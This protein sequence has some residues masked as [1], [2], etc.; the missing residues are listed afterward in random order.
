MYQSFE[1]DFDPQAGAPRLAEVRAHMA[2]A[3]L[4]VFLVPREDAY[5]GE[6]VP[7]CGERLKWLTGFGGS[8]GI[9]VVMADHAALLVDGRYVLQAPQQVDTECFEIVPVLETRLQDWLNSHVLPGQTIGF[10]PMLHT[11][12]QITICKKG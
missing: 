6:Y 2:A 4:D 9:A 1:D 3:G 5:M 10:D 8:A 7:A 11:L 12:N